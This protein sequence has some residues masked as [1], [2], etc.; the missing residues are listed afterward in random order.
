VSHS[1]CPQQ[2]VAVESK[3]D[4]ISVVLPQGATLEED[5]FKETKE[6]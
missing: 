6:L 2:G 3:Q 5:R 4:T 1:S